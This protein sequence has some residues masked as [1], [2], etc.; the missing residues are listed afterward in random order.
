MNKVKGNP[1]ISIQKRAPA[2]KVINGKAKG[3]RKNVNETIP[4]REI[5]SYLTVDTS[6]LQQMLCCGRATA[7]KIGILANAKVQIGKRVLWN[8]NC[9]QQYLDNVVA[10]NREEGDYIECI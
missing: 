1:I 10:D 9:V 3:I 5:L 4:E 7:V 6:K 2:F 8:V